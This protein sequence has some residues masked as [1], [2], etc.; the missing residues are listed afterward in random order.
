[1]ATRKLYAGAKIAPTPWHRSVRTG[2]ATRAF[3][4]RAVAKREGAKPAAAAVTVKAAEPS[5]PNPQ[6]MRNSFTISKDKHAVLGDLKPRAPRLARPVEKS[7]V[8]RA[9]IAA[10]NESA[11]QSFLCAL[12]AVPSL[13]RERP[14]NAAPS[15]DI[16]SPWRIPQALCVFVTDRRYVGGER[17]S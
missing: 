10:L 5:K 6:R 8:L 12:G 1:M 16:A 9:G 3:T 15:T 17:V 2:T 7:K 4:A 11:D 14:R 13:K